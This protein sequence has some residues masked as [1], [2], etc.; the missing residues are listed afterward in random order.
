MIR[1]FSGLR[2]W[3][4]VVLRAGPLESVRPALAENTSAKSIQMISIVTHFD[5]DMVSPFKPR[6]SYRRQWPPRNPG[7]RKLPL[8][9]SRLVFV[10]LCKKYARRTERSKKRLCSRMDLSLEP[11]GKCVDGK[12]FGMR[13]PLFGNR[14]STGS[15]KYPIHHGVSMILR[16]TTANENHCEREGTTEVVPSRTHRSPKVRIFTEQQ[17]RNQTICLAFSLRPSRLSGESAVRN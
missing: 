12:F 16:V 15:V 17:S 10:P 2:V 11:K 6:A 13:I 8:G 14:D 4:P 9:V 5:L 1:G 3:K 7:R